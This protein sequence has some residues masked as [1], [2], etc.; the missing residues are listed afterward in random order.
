MH[1]I[2]LICT[3]YY[4]DLVTCLERNNMDIFSSFP[5][6]TRLEVDESILLDAYVPALVNIVWVIYNYLLIVY[7]VICYF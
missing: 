2:S 4:V 3:Y 1:F 5:L 6:I 7:M